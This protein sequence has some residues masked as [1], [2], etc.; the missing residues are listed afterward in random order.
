MANDI[1]GVSVTGLK[2]SQTALRTVGHNIANAGTEGYSRQRVDPVTNPAILR[3]GSY[4]GSGANINSVDRI[5][6]NFVIEQ[7]RTDTTL[8]NDLDSFYNQVSQLD[9]LLS[10][11]STGLSSSLNNFFAALQNGSDDPTS[12]PSRELIISEAENLSDR[13]NSI[14]DR[15]GVIESGINDALKVAVS[16]VNALAENIAQLN[17]KV[18]DALGLGGSAPPNDLIDQ[19]DKALKE[20]SELV[21]LKVFDQGNGQINV[22][23]GNGQSLVI[24]PNSRNIALSSNPQD[25]RKQDIIFRTDSVTETIT[26]K[27]TGGEIGGLLRA[28]DDLLEGSYNQLGRIAVVLSERFNSTHRQGLDLEGEFGGDFFFDINNETT[29]QN[30][31]IGHSSN[32]LPADRVLGLYIRD[33]QALTTSDYEL[34]IENGSLYRVI[35]AEDGV[36]VAEGLMPGE[37]PFSLE[38]DGL[39]LEFEQGSFQAGD[40]FLLQPLRTAAQDFSTVVTAAE[41]IAFASPVLT[42]A[43]LGNIGSGAISAGEV[44]SLNDID[45]NPLPLLE[46]AGEMNP[47]LKIVF[48]TATTY[49]ILDN[50][51][52]GNPQQLEPPIRNQKYIPGQINPLFSTDPGET[53]V[54]SDGL[55]MGL[56]EGRR[57]DTLPGNES[58]NGLPAEIITFTREPES[59]GLTPET[60]RLITKNDASAKEIAS[61]LSNVP[62]VSASAF[63][64]VELSN[65]NLTFDTPLQLTLNGESLIEY[66]IDPATNLPAISNVVPNPVTRPE[67]FQNYLADRIN[68]NDTFKSLGIYAVAGQDAVSGASELRIFST[69]GDDFEINFESSVNDTLFVSDGDNAPLELTGLGA[70][71]QEQITVGGKLDVTMEDGLSLSTSPPN[72]MLF[73]D[74]TATDFAL[75]AYLGIQAQITGTPEAG[76]VFTIDFNHDAAM[77]N[78]N[79]LNLIELE[80]EKIFNGGSSSL[81]QAYGT[82]VE[83]VGI[84]TNSTK[85][86][87]DAAEQVLQ[88][89]QS[90]RDSI[91]GVNLDEEAADLIRFE[92]LFSANAQVI[93]VARDV[94]DRLINSF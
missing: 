23:I 32:N 25:A 49:D 51:D 24:G 14:Y 54:S 33:V 64:Y 93:S 66:G 28:R 5:V 80:D 87:R 50:S 27:V 85:I 1:L 74:T 38:F 46:T 42:D 86:N 92:Q 58:G 11:E 56:P 55:M 9:N 63:N 2:V 34:S 8:F 70:G 37:F 43:S 31:V 52:P 47:P 19:R 82:L 18:S 48:T 77:D 45:G 94:F 7:L 10:D 26:D 44:L 39:E 67:D 68:E 21:S 30:R 16:Q 13:F 73:G 4:V 35:R 75:P 90:L 60:V 22:V 88:Q 69:E 36:E 79:A 61:Q 84:E 83:R 17:I 20:L 62:G 71:A 65:F 3:S 72:S 89:T 81:A 76:D 91:S 15:F 78:R 53:R 40:R 12:I 29:A 59:P 6:N 41:D 57:P